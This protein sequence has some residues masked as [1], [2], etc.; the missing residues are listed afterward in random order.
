MSCAFFGFAF[1]SAHCW[2]NR[3][4]FSVTLTPTFANASLISGAKRASDWFSAAY[5][6]VSLNPPPG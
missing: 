2:L 6:S 3:I 1:A 4:G 5:V